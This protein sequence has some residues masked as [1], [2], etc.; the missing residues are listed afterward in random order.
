M[1]RPD[2]QLRRHRRRASRASTRPRSIRRSTSTT[3]ISTDGAVRHQLPA[4]QVPARDRQGDD[5]VPRSR[6]RRRC[7]SAGTR[8][9][10]ASTR[11]PCPSPGDGKAAAAI[12]K[13][14]AKKVQNICKACGG[15]DKAC[16][17]GDDLTP[18]EI[19]FASSCPGRDRARRRL[20]L[21]RRASSTLQD[22]V[23]CVD[24]VT[25]FKVDCMDR[26]TVPQFA[27]YPPECNPTS[28]TT[29][30]STTTSSTTTTRRE[31]VRQRHG[32]PGRAVRPELAGRRV[33]RARR[34]RRARRSARACRP[35]RRR[36]ADDDHHDDVVDHQHDAS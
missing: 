22:V 27:P 33:P 32:R 21:R 7:R 28:S 35:R 3:A 18:A 4:Q 26:L 6:S 2:R 20:E 23:D 12:Q 34:A 11:T 10:R 8:A 15:P 24:C 30:S 9:S 14:E 16:G 29:T 36:R 17:G 31:H 13:A 1:Q 5:E 25:E 19:G